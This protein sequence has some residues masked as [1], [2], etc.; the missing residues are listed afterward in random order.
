ML[1]RTRR[2]LPLTL[3]A[4]AFVGAA[5]AANDEPAAKSKATNPGL[6]A[7]KPPTYKV[8]KAPF[9]VEITL[10]GMFES[11]AMTEVLIKPEVWGPGMGGGL[12]V[13][14]AAEAGATVKA[15]DVL[16]TLDREK[17]DRAIRDQ[18]A[19]Q[20]LADLAIRMAELDL[21]I[22]ERS[23]PLELA[24]AERAK[25]RADE[26]LRKFLSID[27]P[28]AVESAEFGVRSMAH[29][30]EYVEEELKQLE[31][32]YRKKDLTEET[33]EIILKRQRNQVDSAKFMLKQTE[34]RRDQT[35]KVDLPRREQDMKEGVTRANISYEKVRTTSPL[36]VSQKRLALEKAK[37]ERAR[38]AEKLANLK[39]DRELFTIKSPAEGIVYYG[40]CVQGQWPTAAGLVSRLQKGGSIQ[41]DEVFMTIVRPWPM[42]V[43]A[44]VEE[45]DRGL[46]A[47]GAACKVT[48]AALP[49]V[50]LA[51]KIDRVSRVP[52]GGSFEAV[53]TFDAAPGEAIVPGMACT[54]KAVTYTNPE[55]VT[56]PAV[57]VFDDELN[58]DQHYVYKVGP[59]GPEKHVVTVGKRSGGRA[60]ITSG[61]SVGDE[62]LLSKP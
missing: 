8:E 47:A 48:P 38:G 51:G 39:K 18:E 34:N 54:V 57:A 56:V 33:E 6:G 49:D 52:V 9:K 60:E 23:A 44:A 43:R 13:V 31:K 22:T 5:L 27:K 42:T 25:A 26:D 58:E 10:K 7:V 24:S 40:R 21:P 41:A 15:G 62:I 32:M 37:Y 46:V 11:G 2:L 35:L 28:L 14:K 29:N 1:R 59:K 53:V 30:L 61:L 17:I 12:T 50:K 45:K 20:Q 19:D 36:G 55:A 3:L 16:L 4:V